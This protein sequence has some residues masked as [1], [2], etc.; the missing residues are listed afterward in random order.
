ME[1]QKASLI[2]DCRLSQM[3]NYQAF[4]C[5]LY[6]WG[7]YHIKNSTILYTYRMTIEQKTANEWLTI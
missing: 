4:Q 3:S 7:T 5:P 2:P 1:L 6:Y